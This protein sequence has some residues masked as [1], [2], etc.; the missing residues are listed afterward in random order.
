MVTIATRKQTQETTMTRIQSNFASHD[1][2]DQTLLVRN[3]RIKKGIITKD[4]LIGAALISV[5]VAVMIALCGGN[6]FGMIQLRGLL[7]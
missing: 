7:P 6:V 2:G 3:P 5:G 1:R 4:H